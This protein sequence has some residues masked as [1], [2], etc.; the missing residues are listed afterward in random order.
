MN[1]I[2]PEVE[3]HILCYSTI[4][5]VLNYSYCS[6]EKYELVHSSQYLWKQHTLSLGTE[7]SENVTNWKEEYIESLTRY[8][9]TWHKEECLSSHIQIEKKVVRAT[10]MDHS[11]PW[12]IIPSKYK[13]NPNTITRIT[14][15]V[16]TH[17]IYDDNSYRISLGA[18]TEPFIESQEHLWIPSLLRESHNMYGFAFVVGVNQMSINSDY[19]DVATEVKEGDKIIFQVDNGYT[20]KNNVRL[21]VWW[22]EKE[23]HF[24]KPRTALPV[25]VYRPCIALCPE[26]AAS[27]ERIQRLK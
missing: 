21:R 25:M 8:D 14:F 4:E 2:V 24:K 12:E 17:M 13:L 7:P 27:L 3:L 22:N 11:H 26:Q 15:K 6:R 10:A 9:T 23:I 16:Q 5:T 18:A 20:S 19:F 1:T